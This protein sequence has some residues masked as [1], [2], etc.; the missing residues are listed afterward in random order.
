MPHASTAPRFS[1]RR[2]RPP[3]P[4]WPA[5]RSPRRG[6]P[7]RSRSAWPTTGCCRRAPSTRSRASAWPSTSARARSISMR[8]SLFELLRPGGMLLNHAIAALDPEHDPHEDLFSTRYVFPDGEPLPLSRIQLALERAGFEVEHVEG[9]RE[10]YAT[11][12]RHWHG[13]LDETPRGAERLAGA[14]ADADLAAL[15]AGGAAWV[16]NTP[17]EHLPGQSS[18]AGRT[19]RRAFRPRARRCARWR[20]P[21]PPRRAPAAGSLGSSR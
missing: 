17:H 8:A 14:G 21:C 11:T 2:S 18:P 9:F 5:R 15:P 10:D 7:T 13:R 1:E 6:S 4:S 12:L 3:R 20:A 19:D 16:R